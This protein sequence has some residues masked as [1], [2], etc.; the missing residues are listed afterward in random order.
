MPSGDR[1]A[2][3][4]APHPD[5]LLLFVLALGAAFL[6]TNL[7]ATSLWTD[8][9]ETGCLARNILH[10]GVPKAFDGVNYVSQRVVA[11]REDF[12]QSLVWVLSPWLQLYVAAASFAALGVSNLAARLPFALVGIANLWM[13]YHLALVIFADRR[14]ARLAALLLVFCIPFLLHMRQGRYYA[15]VVFFTMAVVSTYLRL[16]EG[17]RRSALLL[18]LSIALLFH[19][20]YGVCLPAVVALVIH[21]AFFARS[22]IE[23]G[24]AV[25]VGAGV[26]ALT[27]PYAV[28]AEIYRTSSLLDLRYFRFNL[29]NYLITINNYVLPLALV[30]LVLALRL[31][32]RRSPSQPSVATVLS[33]FQPGVALLLLVVATSLLFASSSANYFFRYAINLVPLL[34]VI[35]A[36]LLI[37]LA[38]RAGHRFGSRVGTALLWALVPITL[39][40]T[41]TA[42]P[43]FPLLRALEA[44]APR[45]PW[46]DDPRLRR[47]RAE[48][49]SLSSEIFDFVYEITHPFRG[50]DSAIADF[51]KS[52]AEPG[53]VVVVQYGDVPLI[54]YT[55]LTVRGVNQGVPFPR[56]PDWIVPR[57]FES[58]ASLIRFAREHGYHEYVLD[59]ADTRWENQPDPYSHKFRSEPVAKPGTDGYPPIVVYGRSRKAPDA[60]GPGAPPDARS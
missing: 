60:D 23:L 51:L 10:F 11:G 29:L 1:L 33:F 24:T 44:R 12:N 40:T 8:E 52:H 13:I 42:Q 45:E 41:L 28:Y 27:A 30:L 26:V 16:L 4:A 38:D 39:F 7:G 55:G 58:P 18:V 17:R 19:S 15:L 49:A 9:A 34:V 36:A 48:Y 46:A 5:P 37:E 21:A 32:A 47:P 59:V 20:N 54:F 50:P 35:H 57:A 2:P 14:I 53:D 43:V 22:R 3:R 25:A 6:L 31:A 56:E